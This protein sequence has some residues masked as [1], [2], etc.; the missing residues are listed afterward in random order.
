L[1]DEA[2][3]TETLAPA[4]TD[5][6][7]APAVT[8]T[9]L[10]SAA[11][12]GQTPDPVVAAPAA[13]TDPVVE[14][15][16]VPE[17][18][19]LT[20]PEG[21]TLDAE[22]VADATPVFKELGL[23]NDQANKLMP[24]AKQFADRIVAAGQKQILDSIATERAAWLNEAKADADIGG[25]HW[26][27]SMTTAATALDALGFTKGSGFR[28]LLDESGLG[29][30]PDMIRAFVKIGKAVAED[31]NFARGNAPIIKQDKASVLYP[32]DVPKGGQ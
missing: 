19:E 5:A 31:S 30:H 24:V 7:V 18:Y 28:N 13:T 15:P 8:E 23:T 6:V 12:E 3:S 16:V 25:Q 22:S 9:A 17:A 21:I 32:D 2:V 1:A 11:V 4:A 26:N 20:A 27:A 10:G 29:N 14:A